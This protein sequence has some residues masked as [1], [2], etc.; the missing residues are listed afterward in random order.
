MDVENLCLLCEKHVSQEDLVIVTRGLD[1]IRNSSIRRNDGIAEQ[2]EGLTSINVHS[3]CR[4]NY[5][6]ESSIVSA[7]NPSP[8]KRL[9]TFRSSLEPFDFK[10]HCL[11]CG[12][13]CDVSADKKKP[14]KRRSVY[15][16]R[17]MSFKPSIQTAKASRNGELRP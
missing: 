14:R 15:E 6:R 9:K 1:T 16:V 11:F 13:E 10:Q 2:L 3:I 17:T 7:V 5:T 12:D 8:Q 4:R